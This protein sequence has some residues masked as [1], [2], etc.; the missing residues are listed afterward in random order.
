MELMIRTRLCVKRDEW[1]LRKY[2]ERAK[3]QTKKIAVRI[4]IHR[5]TGCKQHK[6]A[7]I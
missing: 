7:N 5:N 4:D 2:S 1:V 3:K 6:Y